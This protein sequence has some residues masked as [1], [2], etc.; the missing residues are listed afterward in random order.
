MNRVTW[1][2]VWALCI[3]MVAPAAVVALWG[4]VR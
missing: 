3:A 2:Q 4:W 1:G